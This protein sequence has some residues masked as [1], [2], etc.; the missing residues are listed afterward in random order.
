MPGHAGHDAIRYRSINQDFTMHPATRGM[1]S[2][3]VRHNGR[4]IRLYHTSV[5]C[6]YGEFSKEIFEKAAERAYRKGWRKAVVT[7]VES[8]MQ[9]FER[10]YC[11]ISVI[12]LAMLRQQDS[13]YRYDQILCQMDDCG[14]VYREA[15]AP[16]LREEERNPWENDG[17]E[18]WA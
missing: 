11:D 8:F 9:I 1:S 18:A 6:F 3:I 5:P 13:L 2:R 15:S 4:A 7:Y 10:G 14:E 16:M 17:L 12:N